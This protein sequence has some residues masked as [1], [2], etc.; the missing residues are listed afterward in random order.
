[1]S[2][3]LELATGHKLYDPSYRF[4]ADNYQIMNYG[5]GGAVSLHM[6]AANDISGLGIG[7]V[8]SEIFFLN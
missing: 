2:R 8:I 1:M 5:Y 6:D 7:N 4:T 3:R